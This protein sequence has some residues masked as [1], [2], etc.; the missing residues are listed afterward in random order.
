MMDNYGSKLNALLN[1]LNPAGS[2]SQS[3]LSAPGPIHPPE[4]LLYD[5]SD[6]F[7]KI[8]VETDDFSRT[9]QALASYLEHKD[10]FVFKPACM[11][12]LSRWDELDQ[13]TRQKVRSCLKKQRGSPGGYDVVGDIKIPGNK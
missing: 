9:K 3:T 12:L 8:S 13:K 11:G 6:L 7:S 1:Q 5:L 2:P 4:Y 10:P